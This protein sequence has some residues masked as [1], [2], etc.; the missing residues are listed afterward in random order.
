M[1]PSTVPDDQFDDLATTI[2][3]A[4]RRMGVAGLPRNYELFY[5]A[6]I[7][8]NRALGDDLAALGEN[9][10]QEA[11]DELGMKH[12]AQSDRQALVETAYEQIA[13]RAQEILALVGRERSSLERFGDVLD[14]T[15]GG[16]KSNPDVSRELMQKVVGIMATA[17]DTT[18]EHGRQIARAMEEK[19]A[20]LEDV[21]SK[22]EKYKMLADTDPLTRIWNRRA[23]DKRLAG[24]YESERGI[25]FGALVLVDID[26]FKA[27]NDRYGHPVGDKVLQLVAQLLN[28]QGDSATFVARTGGEEFALVLEGFSE[29]GTARVAEAARAAI[30]KASFVVGPSSSDFGPI[31]VSLGVCMASDAGDADD[32]YAK[33][34]RAL[35]A[36]KVEGRDRVS[37]YS[38]LP[39]GTFSKNWLLY[40]SE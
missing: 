31:T 14:Q 3:G 37:V 26:D 12:F 24:I 22:L 7:G 4:M 38:R 10:A 23:F 9:P 11:L 34:D 2:A 6:V 5:E 21:K 8:A 13:G 32:L 16:L 29:D 40:R 39:A 17:T 35:Y 28:A 19:S 15:S 33:A 36:A 18:L 27:F 25:M 20:E 30:A 1:R